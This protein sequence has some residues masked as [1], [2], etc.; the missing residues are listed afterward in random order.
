VI[1]LAFIG[2][3]ATLVTTNKSKHQPLTLF[4]EL[5]R[6]NVFRVSIAYIVMAWLVMQVADVI[7]NNI[8][9]PDWIFHVLLLFLLI[10]FPFA[11][12]FAW[13]FEM[14]PDGVKREHEIDRSESITSQTG[15]KLDYLIIAVLIFAVGYF[16]YDKFV[17]SEDREAASIKAAVEGADVQPD[18]AM[19]NSKSIAV[20]PF[21]NMSSDKEQEYFSDGLSEELL[22]LLAKIP[23]LQV[24]ARTSSFSFKGQ[25][26]E[27]PVIAERLKVA[28]VL[29]GSVR[30]SGNQVRITAQLIHAD[31]GYHLWSDT[32]DRTLD[33]VFAIQDEIAAEVV[34]QLKISLLGEAPKVEEIDPEAYSLYLQARHNRYKLTR[35]SYE[36]AVTLYEQALTID[37]NY[38][39]AWAG[40]GEVYSI[41][42]SNGFRSMEEGFRLAHETAIKAREIDPAHAPTHAL[43][44]KLALNV[45]MLSLA[46]SRLM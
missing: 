5:K 42:A 37:P 28:H 39:A 18:D 10:G 2:Q 27:I 19:A 8:V 16:A 11:V 4:D 23:E 35:E 15:R 41:Q 34:T 9:A 43:L 21:I 17:L 12:F 31:D 1:L 13:A 38:A 20:L 45:G 30:K 7:L 32:Y 22:N 25:N 33:D 40:L 6:R 44:G 14:T 24:A 36:Q 26:L 29:E 3:R 46:N